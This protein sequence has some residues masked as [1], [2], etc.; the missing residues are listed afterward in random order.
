MILK[1]NRELS[2]LTRRFPIHYDEFAGTY[3]AVECAVGRER[4]FEGFRSFV[5]QSVNN[6]HD[7]ATEL[8]SE[9]VV[10]SRQRMESGDSAVEND[11]LDIYMF[12]DSGEELIFAV[13]FAKAIDF[14]GFGFGNPFRRSADEPFDRKVLQWMDQDTS[15]GKPFLIWF[16]DEVSSNC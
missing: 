10:L 12:P 16:C 1:S 5:G 13:G 15:S 7:T 4:S 3:V 2:L 14:G 11:C 8:S 9:L 6:L